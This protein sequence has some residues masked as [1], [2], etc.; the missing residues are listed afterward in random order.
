MKKLIHLLLLIIVG[1]LSLFGLISLITAFDSNLMTVYA[2]LKLQESSFASS[3]K[4]YRK[5]QT[6]SLKQIER[7]RS[8]KYEYDV[9]KDEVEK[10]KRLL[11]YSV[12]E[13]TKVR[14][15]AA[16]NLPWVCVDDFRQVEEEMLRKIAWFRTHPL[17][18][19]WYDTLRIISLWTIN[20]P[21]VNLPPRRFMTPELL[22]TAGENPPYVKELQMMILFGRIAYAIQNDTDPVKATHHGILEMIELYKNLKAKGV[23]IKITSIE[24]Y[25]HLES[26]G[27]LFGRIDSVSNSVS[28]GFRKRKR[29]IGM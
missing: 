23:E 28:F 20:V 16:T 11:S 26:T 17:E 27:S 10:Q 13:V 24:D 1:L 12:K 18:D 6:E 21:Y 2:R 5:L 22:S 3:V 7:Y 14:R 25:I 29:P 19:G 4:K 15:Y 9:L 8:K